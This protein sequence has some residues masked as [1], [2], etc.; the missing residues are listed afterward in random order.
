ME[1]NEL[2]I[3]SFFDGRLNFSANLYLDSFFLINLNIIMKGDSTKIS[4]III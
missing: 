4:K 2:T 1:P 3:D